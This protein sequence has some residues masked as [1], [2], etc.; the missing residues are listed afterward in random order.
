MGNDIEN[1]N[2]VARQA[3]VTEDVTRTDDIEDALSTL[4]RQIEK[5]ESSNLTEGEKNIIINL[6]KGI[7][8]ERIL[9]LLQDSPDSII[10]SNVSN[11]LNIRST[12]PAST[13]I[14]STDH[15]DEEDTQSVDHNNDG[16]TVQ[17]IPVDD[18]IVVA[19]CWNNNPVATSGKNDEGF[20]PKSRKAR[21]G[22]LSIV[23]LL[24]VIII[25]LLALLVFGKNDL[26][27]ESQIQE[28][29]TNHPLP[30]HHDN[31]KKG[32]EPGD[33]QGSNDDM[34]GDFDTIDDSLDIDTKINE[35]YAS[36]TNVG[37][38]DDL[39]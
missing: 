3:I 32:G 13:F 19:T 8:Q 34:Y 10:I 18:N 6:V 20:F 38:H 29:D 17:A 22:L 15:H 23:C 25:I 37:S 30:P 21:I 4:K 24:M 36:E 31:H 12:Q 11:E 39:N 35:S 5:M 14:G 7:E 9:N 2:D 33:N 27:P 16:G 1:N 26:Y 28:I